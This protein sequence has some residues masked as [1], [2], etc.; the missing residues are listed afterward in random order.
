M[1][2]SDKDLAAVQ[3]ACTETKTLDAH[4]TQKHDKKDIA[5][6]SPSQSLSNSLAFW[7]SV[8]DCEDAEGDKNWQLQVSI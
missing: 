6:M 2:V 1:E 3:I 4:E 7:Q 5:G 8:W